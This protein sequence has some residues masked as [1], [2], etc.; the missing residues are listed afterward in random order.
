MIRP[1]VE[2]LPAGLLEGSRASPAANFFANY[3]ANYIARKHGKIICVKTLGDVVKE[4][5]QASALKSDDL[6]RMVR[7]GA[8]TA[9]GRRCK[10]QHID[11][12]I[13]AGDRMPRYLADLE[14]AM[15]VQ[16]GDFLQHPLRT[17]PPYEAPTS[18][19]KA[20]GIG[21]PMSDADWVARMQ[22]L[23]EDESH[24]APAG[25]ASG[26]TKPPASARKR[27]RS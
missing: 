24:A 22:L 1:Q 17:P 21:H 11:Q 2:L 3:S 10:R 9:P 14:R 6:A 16:P 25:A 27:A 26:E 7:S 4:W 23:M 5:L 20:N 12:L 8:K 15:R 19:P 18:K 13:E